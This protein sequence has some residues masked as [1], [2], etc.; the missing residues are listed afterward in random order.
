MKC[1]LIAI[2]L[3]DIMIQKNCEYATFFLNQSTIISNVNNLWLHQRVVF[4]C[5][6]YL[7]FINTKSCHLKMKDLPVKL[8]TFILLIMILPSEGMYKNH[9]RKC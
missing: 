6:L 3:V 8:L 1:K 7:L 4:F 5:C 9:D 2:L